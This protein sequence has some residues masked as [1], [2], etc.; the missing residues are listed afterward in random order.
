[1][2]EIDDKSGIVF[3]KALPKKIP[4]RVADMDNN[5]DLSI[6]TD[7]GNEEEHKTIKEADIVCP[8]YERITVHDYRRE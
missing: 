5:E 2:K 7:F 3:G 4:V 1:M 8:N 6:I